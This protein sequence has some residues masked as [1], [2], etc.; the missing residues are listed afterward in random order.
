[1]KKWFVLLVI[2]SLYFGCNEKSET[3]DQLNG[4]TEREVRDFINVYDTMWAKRDTVA[5]KESMSEN[6]IYF[7]STGST[8]NRERVISWF[9]PPDKYKVDTAMRSEINVTIHGNTAIVSSR[10]IG[11][12]SFDSE[13]FSDDQRCSLTIQKENGKLKLISEHC[14][15][16][17]NQH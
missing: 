10:W 16:I 7:S 14:T 5:M 1:M 2:G 9:T 12:G 11:S 13:R 17:M 8:S 15:Q 3:S 6:Y 4:L